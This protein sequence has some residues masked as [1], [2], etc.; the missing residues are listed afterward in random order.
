MYQPP[1]ESRWQGRIDGDDPETKR[2]HQSIKFLDLNK[3][4]SVFSDHPYS[5]LGFC[6]DE[7]VRRNKGRP[8]AYHGPEAVRKILSNFPSFVAGRELTMYDVGDCQCLDSN[9]ERAQ[10]ELANKVHQLLSI[11][12]RPILI[13]GGHEIVYGHFKGI[14]KSFP[15][16]KIGVINF[17]AHFDNR[18]IDPIVGS[19]S[20]TGFWQLAQEEKDFKYLGLG[21]QHQSNTQQLFD[22]AQQFH[23]NFVPANHFNYDDRHLILEAIQHF[24]Q[25]VDKVYL[26]ICLDVFASAFAPGVS[27]LANQ[28]IVP[29]KIFYD[30]YKTI[31]QSPKLISMDIAELNPTLD[32]DHRTARLAASLIF[33]YVKNATE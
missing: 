4:H 13:G 21:L 17:D 11:H 28:G 3:S 32:I 29:D 9:L 22:L 23:M 16:E 27:A 10:D 26:T 30:A 1:Q 20:G 31:L 19:S 18:P 7:G 12:H 25:Q 14:K 24:I 2:W 5:I 33:E 15:T 6:S 8:G